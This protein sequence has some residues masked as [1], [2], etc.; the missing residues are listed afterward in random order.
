MEDMTK[1][2]QKALDNQIYKNFDEKIENHPNSWEIKFFYKM[3]HVIKDLE[4]EFL[5]LDDM[6]KQN[7]IADKIIKYKKILYSL[8]EKIPNDAKKFLNDLTDYNE[9]SQPE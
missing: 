7:K 5:N 2:G 1:I 9:K 3:Y 6:Q 4:E 8:E